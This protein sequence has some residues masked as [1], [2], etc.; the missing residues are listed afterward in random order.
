MIPKLFV[1][2]CAKV[3]PQSVSI[4]TKNSPDLQYRLFEA[5]S[6][7][8]SLKNN[9]WCREHLCFCFPIAYFLSHWTTTCLLGWWS[10]IC[11]HHLPLLTCWCLLCKAN[12]SYQVVD[13]YK[14]SVSR[15]KKRDRICVILLSKSFPWHHKIRFYYLQS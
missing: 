8:Y 12:N 6:I 13:R 4:M 5:W 15:G 7:I 10:I 11:L 1:P 2:Y 3:I 14:E 9:S